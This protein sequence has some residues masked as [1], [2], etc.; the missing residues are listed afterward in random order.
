MRTRYLAYRYTQEEYVGMINPPLGIKTKVGMTNLLYMSAIKPSS[1]QEERI[2]SSLSTDYPVAILF[3]CV[4]D[5][6][7]WYKIITIAD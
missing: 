7:Q 2:R 3:H 4:D 1:K 6:D 5:K